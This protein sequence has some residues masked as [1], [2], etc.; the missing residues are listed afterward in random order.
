MIA[1]QE[2]RLYCE[3]LGFDGKVFGK[4]KAANIVWHCPASATQRDAD[5]DPY[6]DINGRCTHCF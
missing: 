3:N 5:G 6:G 2:S 4:S 1:W